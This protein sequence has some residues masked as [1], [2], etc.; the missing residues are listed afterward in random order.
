MK[1]TEKQQ[2]FYP[3]I[4]AD[5]MVALPKLEA[6]VANKELDNRGINS[7]ALAGTHRQIGILEYILNKNI[8]L[9]RQHLT[10]S[11]KLRLSHFLRFNS[12]EPIDYS[13]V[14]MIAY[15]DIYNAL[16]AGAFD[17][18]IELADLLGEAPRLDE[19][20]ISKI[21]PFDQSMAYA[22]KSVVLGKNTAAAISKLNEYLENNNYKNFSG[23]GV[24]FDAIISTKSDRLDWGMK[25]LLKGHDA[26]SKRGI[27]RD[28]MDRHLSIWGL[29]VANLA[30]KYGLK[31]CINTDLL[32]QELL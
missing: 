2:A 25:E 17:L 18:A 23:Y 27:F 31:V 13:Y 6:K 24:A 16:A 7:S 15:K 22:I 12:G 3:L 8:A 30:Q 32:P 19:K 9:F 1:I 10:E 11:A 4:L 5:A 26:E 20:S 28:V 14:T 21:H 29:G